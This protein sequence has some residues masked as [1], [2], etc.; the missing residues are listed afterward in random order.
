V[1]AEMRV[2]SVDSCCLGFWRGWE[3]WMGCNA[4]INFYL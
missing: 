1:G 3:P 4:C 2:V